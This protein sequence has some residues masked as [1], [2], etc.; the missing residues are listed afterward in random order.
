MVDNST[1]ILPLK[2]AQQ[3]MSSLAADQCKQ[4]AELAIS[5][6]KYF[7]FPQDMSGHFMMENCNFYNP[8]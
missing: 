8:V 1:K 3:S 2:S 7:D 5:A 4:V 6:E